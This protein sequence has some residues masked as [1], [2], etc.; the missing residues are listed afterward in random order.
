MLVISRRAGE[1]LVIS[2][3][4]RITVISTGSDK[5]TI[6][7]DAPKEIKVIRAEL[8]ETIEENKASSENIKQAD[9]QGI[10][11]LLKGIEKSNHK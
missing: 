3:Q 2:D 6:G 9:F 8:M 5:V 1:S 11:T 4:I 7:V 10:A